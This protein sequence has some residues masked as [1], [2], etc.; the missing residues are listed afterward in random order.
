MTF[1]VSERSKS[2]QWLVYI[3]KC[4]NGD[5]YTGITNNLERR[6]EEHKIGK[7]GKFT[8]AFKASELLYS[9][10]CASKNDALK[11]EAQIKGW[12][13]EKKLALIKG[14]TALL[15]KL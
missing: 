1:M 11:R 15:N 2:N 3:L 14:D 8:H 4:K 5:L 13:R 6:F 10:P 12:T 9:E 7:G